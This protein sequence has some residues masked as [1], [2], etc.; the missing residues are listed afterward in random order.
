MINNIKPIGD[1]TEQTSVYTQSATK[2]DN[3]S[4]LQAAE[5]NSLSKAT[6]LAHTKI[7][8]ILNDTNPEISGDGV[9]IVA[10]NTDNDATLALNSDYIITNEA[11]HIDLSADV[12]F[13]VA[14]GIGSAGD[15]TNGKIILH[16]TE[17]QPSSVQNGD[18]HVKAARN[19][20]ISANS[21]INLNCESVYFNGTHTIDIDDLYTMLVHYAQANP[22]LGWSSDLEA[23]AGIS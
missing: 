13:K 14:A 3:V 22:S 9:S 6:A 2:T 19:L 11:P 8:A 15:R 20:D 7:N 4:T 23:D 17:E 5:W 12:D 18:I 16:T 21:A 10:D 1:S